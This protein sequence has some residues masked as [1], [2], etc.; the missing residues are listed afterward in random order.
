[1]TDRDAFLRAVAAAPDDDT[2]RLVF[3]DWLDEHGEPKRAEFI[4][5]QCEM[6]QVEEFGPR[7]RALD[8]RQRAIPAPHHLWAKELADRKV[9]N[10]EF[11]RGFVDE[12]TVYSKRFVTEA[13]ELLSLAPIRRVKF[14]NLTAA[15]GNVPLGDLLRC[16]ALARLRGLDFANAP[17]PDEAVEQIAGCERLRGLRELTL[18]A[19]HLTPAACRAVLRSKN[20]EAVTDLTLAAPFDVGPDGNALVAALAAEPGF[21]RVARF[22]ARGLGV[23]P[24][25]AAALTKSPHATGL[26]HLAVG[27]AGLSADTRLGPKGVQ[28]LAA[29]PHLG[30]LTALVITGQEIG[31]GGVQALA[32]SKSLAGLR[33][34]DLSGNP[35][36]PA[37]VAALVGA[38]GL[39]KLV[40]LE[41]RHCL[42]NVERATLR[43]RFAHAA[44]VI[45]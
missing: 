4:R 24:A 38:E 17:L 10:V 18:P 5:V 39:G 28:A 43:N 45:E 33:H 12:V 8:A 13:D 20:L 27:G 42:V 11:H 30:G 44:V 29:S 9:L 23:G 25:G 2:P 37:M 32:G 31:L 3:A 15:R 41:L 6:E 36:T 21:R 26:R 35:F 40:S 16:P 7:W 14:A 22:T 34:L 1:M 19:H